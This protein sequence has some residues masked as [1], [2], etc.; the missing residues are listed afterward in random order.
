MKSVFLWTYCVRLQNS[1][2]FRQSHVP[3]IV[4]KNSGYQPISRVQNMIF[5]NKETQNRINIRPVTFLR[6][7]LQKIHKIPRQH[8][9]KLADHICWRLKHQTRLLGSFSPVIS[10]KGR[11]WPQNRRNVQTPIDRRKID[12]LLRA[13]LL[14]VQFRTIERTG[15]LRGRPFLFPPDHRR[16]ASELLARLK[17]FYK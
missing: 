8:E 5:Q 2:D 14:L 13:Q 10:L 7:V 3:H 16:I 15:R 17:I 11:P 12:H 1:H 9:Q 6:F 4:Q